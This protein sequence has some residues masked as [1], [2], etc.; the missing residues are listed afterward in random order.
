MS[1]RTASEVVPD[2]IAR[3]YEVI[4]Q[5]HAVAYME[6]YC[7]KLLQNKKRKGWY[8]MEG[9]IPKKIELIIDNLNLESLCKKYKI[10]KS[11]K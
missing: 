8:G 3:M 2:V 11:R 7:K 4:L 1:V 5:G 10:T 6:R 9:K